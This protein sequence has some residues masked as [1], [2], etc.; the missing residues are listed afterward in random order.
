MQIL[1]VEKLGRIADWNH[2]PLTPV[3]EEKE[4]PPFF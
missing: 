4:H 2:S 3:A 1:S